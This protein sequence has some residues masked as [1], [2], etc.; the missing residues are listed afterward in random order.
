[1][2]PRTK[3][4]I[5]ALDGSGISA[6]FMPDRQLNLIAS[7]EAVKKGPM[8]GAAREL[9]RRNPGAK[10]MLITPDLVVVTVQDG[11][12]VFH[13]TAHSYRDTRMSVVDFLRQDRYFFEDGFWATKPDFEVDIFSYRPVLEPLKKFLR[14]L[15][16]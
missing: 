13:V 9:I 2:E 12:L 6:Y 8:Q 15:L 11:R 5:A 10:L 14:P 7:W 3:E 1:M 16:G 4:L